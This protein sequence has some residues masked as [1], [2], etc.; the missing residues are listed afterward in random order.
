MVDHTC[1]SSNWEAE[2]GSGVKPEL[3]TEFE[4]SMGYIVFLRKIKI[5]LK[6]Y[7]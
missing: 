4:A 3:D 7:T 6:T 5:T 1:S 2:A